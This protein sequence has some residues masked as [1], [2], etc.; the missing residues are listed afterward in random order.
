[1]ATKNATLTPFINARGQEYYQ[2]FQFYPLLEPF[3]TEFEK[4]YNP[5]PV[6]DYMNAN[7]LLPII[8]CVGYLIFCYFGQIIMK[9]FKGFDLKWALAAWNLGLSIFSFVGFFRVAPHLLHMII[10][11]GVHGLI[12]CEP[13]QKYGAGAT[14]FWIQMFILSKFPELVDTV[15]IVLR[16]RKLIFLHWYHHITVLLYC[17]HSYV[18]ENAAGIIFCAMNY[19]VHAIMYLYYCFQVFKYKPRW[20]KPWFITTC[21]TSQMFVGIAVCVTSFYIHKQNEEGCGIEYQ[22][23]VAGAVMYASYFYLFVAFAIKRYLFTPA[24][25]KS[26]KSKRS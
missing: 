18:T 8:A 15:F 3:Y 19:G 10:N 16:K 5:K 22:N 21:Q 25:G 20:L 24:N 23:I 2:F 17:W 14:G 4:E 26:T 6:L 1:M 12:C 7:P 11:D 9:K 13:G